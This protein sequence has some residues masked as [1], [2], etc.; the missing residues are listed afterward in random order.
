MMKTCFSDVKQIKNAQKSFFANNVHMFKKI[1]MK[2][3][4]IFIPHQIMNLLFHHHIFMNN[5]CLMWRLFNK[6]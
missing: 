1:E 3:M 2:G 5:L 6:G 4:R